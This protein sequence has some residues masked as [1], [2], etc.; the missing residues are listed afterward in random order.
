MANEK[1]TELECLRGFAA[2]YV[3]LGHLLVAILK[4]ESP[5][6][7]IFFQFGQE[8]VMV[9]FL[10]SGFVIHYSMKP[11]TSWRTYFVHRFRRIYP[12]FII[13]LGL[14]YLSACV[15]SGSLLGLRPWELLG[16]LAMLQDNA[17][18]K[19]GTLVDPYFENSPFWS[20]SYEWWFYMLYYPLERFVADRY[21]LLAVL[22]LSISGFACYFMHPN[23]IALFLTYFM[24]WWVGVEIARSYRAQLDPIPAVMK[25]SSAL[26]IVALCLGG[27]AWYAHAVDHVPLQSGMDPLLPVRHFLAAIAIVTVGMIWRRFGFIGF[28]AVFGW[29]TWLAPISYALYIIH[30]P[31]MASGILSAWPRVA[32]ACGYIAIIIGASY[33][34]EVHF[35]KAVNRFLKKFMQARSSEPIPAAA[36]PASE[37]IRLSTAE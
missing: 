23:Q 33:L 2:S 31:I 3:F 11:D 5:L 30:Y 14:S 15:R 12:I 6:V 35:Q 36:L 13:A 8:A 4:V 19:P 10:L 21:R 18:L 24:I 20:L 34:L 9:F 1:I 32:Q 25:A 26:G 37:P 27:R 7:R 17:F 29:F 16:N 28:R 22:A